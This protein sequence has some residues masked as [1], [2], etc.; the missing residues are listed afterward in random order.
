MTPS[1]SAT[2]SRKRIAALGPG[3]CL[4]RF[5]LIATI[6]SGGMGKVWAARQ[7]GDRGFEKLVAVKTGLETFMDHPDFEKFFLDEARVAARIQHPNVCAVLDLG[8]DAGVLYLAMEWVGGG[9]LSALLNALPDRR[10]DPRIAARV[11]AQACAGL[12]AAHEL[13]DENGHSLCVVHRDVSPQNLLLT[14]DGHV[15]VADFGVVRAKNQLHQATSTGE[16]KGKIGYMAPEQFTSTTYDRRAD[17]YALGCTLY[18]AVVGAKPHDGTGMA[19]VY[20]VVQGQFVPPSA[21]R[22]DLPSELERII[23]RAMSRLPEDRYSTAEEM[24][25]ELESFLS[26]SGPPCTEVDV[27]RVIDRALGP[28]LKQRMI[29]IRTA[30][31]ETDASST[32]MRLRDGHKDESSATSVSV[33]VSPPSAPGL[34]GPLPR[35]SGAGMRWVYAAGVSIAVLTGTVTAL[36]GRLTTA[37]ATSASGTTQVPAPAQSVRVL[38][39][40]EPASAAFSIDDGPVLENPYETLAPRSE[41]P[42][43]LRVFAP[44]H[45]EQ[46]R[47][48]TFGEAVDLRVQLGALP[49][50]AAQGEPAPRTSSK[51]PPS[52]R[53]KTD[54]KKAVETTAPPAPPMATE[55][56]PPRVAPPKKTI[57]YSDPFK[58]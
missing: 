38:I 6:A 14:P 49:S 36:R 9:S 46:R 34:N 25:G 53:P 3:D 28:V 30:V 23:L 8:D 1:V 24:R 22:Q 15:K 13:T 32:A 48:F 27:M 51:G 58:E 39:R 42:H 2:D 33:D 50:P 12:H 41:G 26:A 11:F 57:D 37:K 44:G 55:K 16:I 54:P 21:R 56:P 43:V 29:D 18:Q 31:R 45:E 7:R 5:Q 19:V 10:L 20:Q 35:R 4:G 17:I 52:I 40:A 47:T